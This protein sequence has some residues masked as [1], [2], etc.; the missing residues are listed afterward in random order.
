MRGYPERGYPEAAVRGDPETGELEVSSEKRI[1]LIGKTLEIANLVADLGAE[2]EVYAILMEVLTATRRWGPF[3]SAHEGYGIILEEVDELWDAVRLNQSKPDRKS[4]L[5]AEST[6]VAAM[7][8]R[9]MMDIAKHTDVAAK[10][11]RKKRV[12]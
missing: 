10:P 5:R 6:Q 9:F 4:R 12:R 2:D 7:A 3:H 8:L 11:A 1:A